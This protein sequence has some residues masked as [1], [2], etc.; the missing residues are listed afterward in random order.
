MDPVINANLKNDKQSPMSKP[1]HSEKMP[2]PVDF[3]I[4]KQSAKTYVNC[5]LLSK[6][7]TCYINASL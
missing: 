7:N 4:D 2:P 1:I 5:G 3:A 6:E